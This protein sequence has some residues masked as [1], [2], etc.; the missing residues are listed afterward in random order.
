M[1]EH[2]KLKCM[3]AENSSV[4]QMSSTCELS[5]GLFWMKILPGYAER[6]SGFVKCRKVSEIDGETVLV[7][8]PSADVIHVSADSLQELFD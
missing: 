8:V 6:L 4:R 3:T 1:N 7:E 2:L 5:R